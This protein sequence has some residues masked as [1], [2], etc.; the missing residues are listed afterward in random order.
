MTDWSTPITVIVTNIVTLS[1]SLV[2]FYTNKRSK[3]EQE[4]KKRIEE[5]YRA[6]LQVDTCT[7]DQIYAHESN[8]EKKHTLSEFLISR[9]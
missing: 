1:A 5:M 3:K 7:K 4:N 2:P 6:L 8:S 9:R